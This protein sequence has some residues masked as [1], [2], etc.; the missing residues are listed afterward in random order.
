MDVLSKDELDRI[1]VCNYSEEK[2]TQLVRMG[3]RQ[4]KVAKAWLDESFKISD[5]WM[6]SPNFEPNA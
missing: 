5:A 3:G 4:T 1:L 2:G 6:H